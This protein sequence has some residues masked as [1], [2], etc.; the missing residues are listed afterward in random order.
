MAH[1]TN[2]N[3]S[4]QVFHLHSLFLS[5][6]LHLKL[7]CQCEVPE[8]LVATE[9]ILPSANRNL[10]R[11]KSQLKKIQSEVDELVWSQ[12]PN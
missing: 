6:H 1:K 10:E 3:S 12:T 8:F 4:M 9:P 5:M 11:P 2:V 7:C